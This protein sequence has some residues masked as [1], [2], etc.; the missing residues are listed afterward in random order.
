MANSLHLSREVEVYVK[1]DTDYWKVPVLDGFS[2][3]QSTNTAEVQVKEMANASNA[4]RRGRLMF[5]DSLAPAEWSFSTYARPFKRGVGEGGATDEHH[6][7]EEVMWALLNQTP[8]AAYNST[9]NKFTQAD[10]IEQGDGGAKVKFN[11]SNVLTAPEATIWFKFPGNDGADN[12]NTDIWYELSDATVNE[13]SAEFDIDGITTLNWSGMAKSL[14]EASA[15]TVTAITGATM[16]VTDTEIQNT[17]SFIRNRLTQLTVASAMGGDVQASYSLVLT[18]GS[19]TITNNVE[20]VTPASLGVVNQP[21]GHTLG[22]RTVSGSFTCYLDHNT[23]SS[24]D[25]IEDLLGASGS[26]KNKFALLFQ[27]GGASSTPRV[28]FDM[29]QCHLEIPS[30]NVEDVVGVEVNF[31]AL[32]T[33]IGSTD[34]VVVTYVGA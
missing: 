13:C 12:T 31:H 5:N 1:Y 22:G 23:S 4:S 34:E 33:D 25:L 2:F 20:Y 8:H 7:V 6:M 3:S 21:L 28:E 27:V 14:T 15:S 26:V 30:H 10:S 11:K 24:A 32:P 16:E 19:I 29:D 17:G 18:G 9:S